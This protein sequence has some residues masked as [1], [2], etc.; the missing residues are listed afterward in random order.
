MRKLYSATFKAGV[1]HQAVVAE[2]QAVGEA[3]ET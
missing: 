3:G 1:E 2:A